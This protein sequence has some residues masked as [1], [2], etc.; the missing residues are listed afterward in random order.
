MPMIAPIADKI[1]QGAGYKRPN[2]GGDDPNFPAP[3]GMPVPTGPA[4]AGGSGGAA[5]EPGVAEV[6]QNT[7]P[8][9]PPVPQE[10]EQ[11]MQGIETAAV[12]DNLQ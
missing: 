5:A 9:F 4:P 12:T 6:H 2:P 7:S 8:A 1:M 10:A 3:G 11:G